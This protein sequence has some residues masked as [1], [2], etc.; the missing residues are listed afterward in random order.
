[1]LP[2]V[3]LSQVALAIQIFCNS[4]HILGLFYIYLFVHIFEIPHIS[5]IM[6]FVFVWL[7]LLNMTIS[8]SNQIGW[9]LQMTLLHSFFMTE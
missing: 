2:T 7:T 1:M 8:K 6:I 9:L 4:M 3:I 5:N